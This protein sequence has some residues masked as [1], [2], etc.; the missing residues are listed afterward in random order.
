MKKIIAKTNKGKEF[1]YYRAFTYQ[2]SNASA[3]IICK[4]MNDANYQLSDG[5]L[6]KVYTVADYTFKYETM[7]KAVR[8]RDKVR[9]YEIW[10]AA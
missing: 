3:E 10:R 9:F 2:V 8:Y 7:Y 4:A 6:W 5:E 1:M